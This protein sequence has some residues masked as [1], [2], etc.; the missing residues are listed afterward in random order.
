M[1]KILLDFLD[2]PKGIGITEPVPKDIENAIDLANFISAKLT[3]NPT[4]VLI[5]TT[6]L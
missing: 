5:Q 6:T 3:A 4:W 2:V 1:K